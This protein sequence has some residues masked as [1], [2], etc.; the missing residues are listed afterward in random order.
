MNYALVPFNYRNVINP[1]QTA[2]E[3]DSAVKFIDRMVAM[4]K[5][6]TPADNYWCYILNLY[7]DDRN[8]T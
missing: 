6:T 4:T 8:W 7:G 1:W 3:I 2:R 5:G